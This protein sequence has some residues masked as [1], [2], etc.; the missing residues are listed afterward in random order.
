MLQRAW[1]KNLMSL[2]SNKYNKSYSSSIT[3]H[4]STEYSTTQLGKEIIVITI[5]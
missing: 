1:K 2:Y 5:S 3:V 4:V